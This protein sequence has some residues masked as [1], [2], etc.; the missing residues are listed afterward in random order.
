VPLVHAFTHRLVVGLLQILGGILP[1]FPALFQDLW[2]P[3]RLETPLLQSAVS[4]RAR[5]CL[6]AR[7]TTRPVAGTTSCTKFP[8][9]LGNSCIQSMCDYATLLCTTRYSKCRS[10]C[11]VHYSLSVLPFWVRVP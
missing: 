6:G 7:R 4:T 1:V 5:G 9:D 10:L 8:M 11:G 3:R 2:V